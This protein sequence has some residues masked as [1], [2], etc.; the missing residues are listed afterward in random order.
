MVHKYIVIWTY[1]KLYI[2]VASWFIWLCTTE[3]QGVPECPSTTMTDFHSHSYR[4]RYRHMF[5]HTICLHI[6]VYMRERR[7]WS[8]IL[9]HS[10]CV[11]L[12]DSVM[13][14]FLFTPI[15]RHCNVLDSL[16]L[17][18]RGWSNMNKSWRIIFDR[19]EIEENVYR[20]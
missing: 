12:S 18:I 6:Q 17:H 10:M 9:E 5:I 8:K 11:Y 14:F 19:N 7:P 4:Y 16:F 3:L 20:E 13:T 1:R 2:Y 15:S